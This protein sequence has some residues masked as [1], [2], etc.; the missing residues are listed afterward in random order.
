MVGRCQFLLTLFT[1]HKF[2]IK[3]VSVGVFNVV[4]LHGH[5]LSNSSTSFT[6]SLPSTVR[7]RPR[8]FKPTRSRNICTRA[9]TRS[10]M[11]ASS[12]V[13]RSGVEGAPPYTAAALSLILR[14]WFSIWLW[15]I[16]SKVLIK[17]AILVAI[18]V[19]EIMIM[20]ATGVP[21][22][23]RNLTKFSA[24]RAHSI[25]RLRFRRSGPLTAP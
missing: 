10:D 18:S 21:R 2:I 25:S 15:R 6:S 12:D 4:L 9:F 11:I 17:G 5:H 8:S 16:S 23:S 3:L 13:T 14:C 7:L 19:G 22:A 20:G 24:S 1:N